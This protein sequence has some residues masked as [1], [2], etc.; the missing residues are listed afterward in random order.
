M[1]MA[2]P[3]SPPI[4]YESP[5]PPPQTPGNYGSPSEAPDQYE[6]PSESEFDKLFSIYE[7]RF[8]RGE[9]RTLAR[10]IA[11]TIYDVVLDVRPGEVSK[12]DLNHRVAYLCDIQHSLVLFFYAK[13]A[14][15]QALRNKIG[16]PAEVQNTFL[17]GV[18]SS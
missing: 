16:T 4:Y 1:N 9:Y 5:P 2:Q 8:G 3:S 14:S 12:N 15:L 6:V 17:C 11:M 10:A 18:W 13:F 7:Q